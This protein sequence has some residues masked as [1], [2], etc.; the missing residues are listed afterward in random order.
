MPCCRQLP[1]P[2]PY[3]FCVTASGLLWGMYM[4]GFSHLFPKNDRQEI[5]LFG[6]ESP[7]GVRPPCL[8]ECGGLAIIHGLLRTGIQGQKKWREAVKE[9]YSGVQWGGLIMLVTVPSCFL[10]PKDPTM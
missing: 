5:W 3:W 10:S 1:P 9:T 8:E 2:P 4:L 7:C 6:A